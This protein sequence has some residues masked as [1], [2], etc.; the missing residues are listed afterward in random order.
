MSDETV[1]SYEDISTLLHTFTTLTQAQG[2]RILDVDLA[3]KRLSV[4]LNDGTHALVSAPDSFFVSGSN[5]NVGDWYVVGADGVPHHVH[6]SVF[7]DL[8]TK[9]TG[10][11][12][13]QEQG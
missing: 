3:R 5:A 7:G 11:V 12:E 13:G 8:F 4:E 1:N 9:V 6:E 2:G 10:I